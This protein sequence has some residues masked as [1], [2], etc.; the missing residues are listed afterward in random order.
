MPRRIPNIVLNLC[1]AFSGVLAALLL[2]EVAARL[3]PSPYEGPA[4]AIEMCSSQLGW[5][6]KP[7]FATSVSTDDY[8]HDL[9][10]NSVGMHDTDHPLPKPPNTRRILMLGDSFVR[11]HQVRE[12]E[13]AD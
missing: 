13:T 5:R 11:A 9:A 10:L 12:T 4:N 1:L 6:G 2:F 7:H 8:T 3:L